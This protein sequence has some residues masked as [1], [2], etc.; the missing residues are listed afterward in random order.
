M[1]CHA[2][3]HLNLSVTME[4]VMLKQGFIHCHLI[5]LACTYSVSLNRN[6]LT[7]NYRCCGSLISEFIKF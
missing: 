1:T 3:T 6:Q 7:I 2:V 4:T 5:S